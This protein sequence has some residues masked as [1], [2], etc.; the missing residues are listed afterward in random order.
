MPLIEK[1]KEEF[2]FTYLAK[3]QPDNLYQPKIT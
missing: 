1:I 2:T 3:V